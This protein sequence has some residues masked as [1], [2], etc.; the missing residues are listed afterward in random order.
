[1]LVHAKYLVNSFHVTVRVPPEI[2]TVICSYLPTEIDVFSASQVCRYWHGVLISSPSLWTRFPCRHVPR[3]I[4]SLERCNSIPIQLKFDKQ[5]SIA[6]LENVLLRGKKVASLTVHRDAD[7][8]PPL[9]S[10]FGLAISS[11]ERL[12]I[13]S[14][15]A[16][17]QEGEEQRTNDIWQ[18]SLTL[19]ELFICQFPVPIGQFAAPN[20]IHL[21]LENV[22]NEREITIQSILGMLRG[23]P[24]LETILIIH[25]HAPPQGTSLDHSPVPLP[26][27]RSIE[28]GV[29]E[30]RSGLITF[31]RFPPTVAVGF[32]SLKRSDVQGA[33]ILPEVVASSQHVL[34]GID[35]HTVI[36]AVAAP[37]IEDEYLQSLVRFEGV[38]GSLELTFQFWFVGELS[39]LFWHDGVLFSFAPCLDNVKELQI[40]ECFVSWFDF[41][42]IATAMP[43]LASI[44]FFHCLWEGAEVCGMF[45]LVC[46]SSYRTFPFPHLERLTVLEPG[47]GLIRVAQRR[48][49]HGVPLQTV[50]IGTEHGLYTR[51][52]LMELREFVDEVRV[53]TPL[54]ISEWSAGNG[55]LDTW[56]ETGIPGPVGATSDLI[57]VGLTLFHRTL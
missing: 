27:L 20:L 25:A 7:R 36:L 39:V 13:Y 51:E 56:S 34:G 12:H 49:E 32:R 22:A 55:I 47:P 48:K 26:N 16:R 2:L 54:D 10:F 53:G 45:G 42:D 9:H 1:V 8:M 24:L 29:Y 5:S 28:L 50:V 44:C 57:F 4:A 38:D 52:Q 17:G 46:P 18:D 15:G 14:G 40:A 3:T 6:A 30:V 19:R 21:A 35:I 43:N 31:L 23:C 11:L 33:N 41:R 37:R